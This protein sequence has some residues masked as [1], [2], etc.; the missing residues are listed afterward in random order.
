MRPRPRHFAPAAVL[1][2]A[3]LIVM[4]VAGERVTLL[5]AS[6]AL[7]GAAGVLGVAAVFYEIGDSEDRD[8]RA[9]RS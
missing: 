4:A 3:G 5:A 9:G 7:I 8:R 6:I 2:V 1:L